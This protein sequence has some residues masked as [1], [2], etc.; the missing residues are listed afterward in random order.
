VLVEIA[1]TPPYPAGP[2]KPCS[3][4]TIRVRFGIA[5]IMIISLIGLTAGAY[6]PPLGR[7]FLF[8][9][10]L[11][12]LIA[13]SIRPFLLVDD[14]DARL[15]SL[16]SDQIFTSMNKEELLIRLPAMRWFLRQGDLALLSSVQNSEPAAVR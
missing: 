2:M 13:L 7:V 5:P 4:S 6:S 14:D 11:P 16:I 10:L 8:A 1:E 15:V 12:F 3:P 9:I